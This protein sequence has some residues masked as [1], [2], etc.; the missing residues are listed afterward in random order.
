MH[1]GYC[2][3]YLLSYQ[4][5]CLLP[6]R[7]CVYITYGS[8]RNSNY[9]SNNIHWLVYVTNIE[10]SVRQKLDLNYYPGTLLFQHVKQYCTTSTIITKQYA[11]VPCNST[12]YWHKNEN[13]LKSVTKSNTITNE[14]HTFA[15]ILLPPQHSPWKGKCNVSHNVETV[16]NTYHS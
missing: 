9:S 10:C 12:F 5:L 4:I 3:Y 8:Q 2:K 16:W 14:T 1:S 11:T 15:H 6:Q 7:V 13:T